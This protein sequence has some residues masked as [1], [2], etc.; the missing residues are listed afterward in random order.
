MLVLGRY[1]VATILDMPLAI[2]GM[3]AAFGTLAA[4]R[5]TIPQ[6]VATMIHG[7]H[8]THLSMPCFLAGEPDRL[9]V[10]VVTVFPENELFGQPTT[11]GLLVVH[12]AETGRPIAI[13]D[14]EHLTAMRTGAASALATDHLARTNASV[15]LVFG[16]GGQA[17]A[18]MEGMVAVRN[19]ERAFVVSRSEIR[20]IAFAERATEDLGFPVTYTPDVEAVVPLA[21]IICTATNAIEPLFDGSLISPGTHINAIGAFRADMRELD[22]LTICSSRVYVDHT[23]SA[24]RGA[25]DL[26]IPVQQGEFEWSLLAGELG[27]LV[28]GKKAGRVSDKEV[29]VFKAVGVA[30]QDTVVGGIVYD[31]AIELGLGLEVEL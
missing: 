27:D 3:R 5:V 24:I 18:Q 6:R 20:G 11:Q 21:D 1:D 30:V 10:K 29:T 9:T 16:A 15:L 23:E 28:I 25:G 4:K 13:M 7:R 31:K 2:E 12:S 26:I 14:A 22:S 8:A 17:R 19:I